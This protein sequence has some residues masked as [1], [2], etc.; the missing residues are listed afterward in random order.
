MVGVIEN[1]GGTIDK[2]IGDAILAIFGAPVSYEDNAVRACMA[3]AQMSQVLN[4]VDTS[5]LVMPEGGFNIGI[6]IHEGVVIV[7]N[8][9][10]MDKFDYTVVGDTV[11][12]AARLE[13]LTKHY[14]ERILV[15]DSFKGKVEH[16]VF[17]REVDTVKVKGKARPTTL[18]A[19]EM[20][21]EV[22]D[23]VFMKHYNNGLK[24]FKMGN[25]NTALE[26][27]SEAMKI[28]PDDFLTNMY[29]LRCERFLDEPPESWDGS[30]TLDFK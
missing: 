17:L 6:G 2:F 1:Y 21:S 18:Y 5:D 25:W 11:N 22:Y 23:K 20:T 12:L 15:S 3:A 7:G 14:H 27:F 8:I 9:G 13:G 16:V 10:S 30:M 28:V 4:T 19:L 26:Y 24:M 29:I